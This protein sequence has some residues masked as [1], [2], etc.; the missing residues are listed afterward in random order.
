MFLALAESGSVV[1]KGQQ[2]AGAS[3]LSPA[4]RLSL[5]RIR[6]RAVTDSGGSAPADALPKPLP[7]VP[8]LALD[9]SQGDA[10]LGEISKELCR[11]LNL[12]TWASVTS[13]I[14]QR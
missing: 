6:P 11:L 8:G 9:A 4:Q 1:Q 12:T 13:L 10:G 3:D 7:A 5:C 2:I 14:A